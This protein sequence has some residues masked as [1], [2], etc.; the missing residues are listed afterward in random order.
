[1]R[2][3]W[4][5]RG[6]HRVEFRKQNCLCLKI[7]KKTLGKNKGTQMSLDGSESAWSCFTVLLCDVYPDIDYY[8]AHKKHLIMFVE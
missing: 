2:P 8:G 6:M 7:Y 4:M 5:G 3:E 1:M